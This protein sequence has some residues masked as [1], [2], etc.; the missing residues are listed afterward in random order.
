MKQTWHDY[1]IE[2]QDLCDL[3]M[4]AKQELRKMDVDYDLVA[5]NIAKLQAAKR[6]WEAAR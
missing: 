6:E 2:R 4:Q 3:E 5:A 1:F